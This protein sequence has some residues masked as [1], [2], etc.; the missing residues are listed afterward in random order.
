MVNGYGEELE[1]LTR[2]RREGARGMRGRK[3][4]KGL[5]TGKMRGRAAEIWLIREGNG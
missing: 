2:E 3:E 4:R 5:E 1:G